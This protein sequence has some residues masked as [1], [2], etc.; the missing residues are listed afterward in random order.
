VRNS[1]LSR[2]VR[3]L[4]PQRFADERGCFEE[5]YNRGRFER[6]AGAKVDFV[7]DNLSRSVQGV[8]RGLHYQI[9]PMAQGKLV[10][11]M[12]GTIF[13]VAVDIRR[14]SATFGDWLGIELSAE[15][16]NQLWI[17]PGFAHGFLALT[18]SADVLYKTTSLYSPEHNRSVLWDDPA[19]GIAWPTGTVDGVLVSE[20]DAAAPVLEDAEVFS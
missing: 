8:V 7:Q 19:I 16:G 10:R 20:R 15:E 5:L 3:V 14:S 11:A 13:D 1:L 4:T 18:E 9:D 2:D 6:E 17:P 12:V